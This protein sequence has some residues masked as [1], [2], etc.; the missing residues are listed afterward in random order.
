MIRVV[1]YTFFA[2]SLIAQ[3]DFSDDSESQSTLTITG[4]V[5]NASTGHGR[6]V[7]IDDGDLGSAADEDGRYIIEGVSQGATV[8]VTAIG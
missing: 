2:Y 4:I 7:L 1:D 3:D 5:T 8:T 6:N